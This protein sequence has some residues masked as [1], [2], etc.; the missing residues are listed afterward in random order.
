MEQGHGSL[1]PRA[2]RFLS[3]S[4]TSI[5]CDGRFTMDELVKGYKAAATTSPAATARRRTR[6]GAFGHMGDHTPQC[7]EELLALTDSIFERIG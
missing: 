7:I 2:R 3:P 6:T 5:G 1:D 4:V